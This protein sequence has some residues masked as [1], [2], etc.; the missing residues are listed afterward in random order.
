MRKLVLK[1]ECSLDGFVGGE[2]G[3]L[4]WLSPGFDAEHGDWLS[5][6]L[7][8]AGAHLMGKAP[9]HRRPVDSALSLTFCAG[10]HFLS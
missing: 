1:M 8:R 5:E 7:W 9:S 2:R 4:D 6:R 10:S 3:E